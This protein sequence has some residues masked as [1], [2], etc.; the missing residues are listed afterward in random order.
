M[1]ILNLPILLISYG[2]N[3][4]ASKTGWHPLKN[5]FNVKV[6]VTET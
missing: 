2:M 4:K 5:F 6:S 3:Y 1:F